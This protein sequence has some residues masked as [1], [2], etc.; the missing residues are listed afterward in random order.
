LIASDSQKDVVLA[1]KLAVPMILV[2][3]AVLIAAGAPGS[4]SVSSL[5]APDR[6]R[7]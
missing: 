1:V 6:P 7:Q 3:P 2:V 4:I 5:Y